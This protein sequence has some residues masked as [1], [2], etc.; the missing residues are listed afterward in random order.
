MKLF[1]NLLFLALIA[2]FVNCLRHGESTER[3]NGYFLLTHYETTGLTER[4][5]SGNRWVTIV[6]APDS[7]QESLDSLN[8]LKASVFIPNSQNN[9]IRLYGFLHSEVK[10]TPSAPGRAQ[11][12]PYQEFT[13]LNWSMKTPFWEDTRYNYFLGEG[14]RRF[15]RDALRPDDFGRK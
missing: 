3:Q 12:E 11:S 4:I 1:S 14:G 10:W 9:N 13:L 6:Y 7:H 15:R 2:I 5:R 8:K